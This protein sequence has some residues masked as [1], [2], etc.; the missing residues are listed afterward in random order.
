MFLQLSSVTNDTEV[1]RWNLPPVRWDQTARYGYVPNDR[2]KNVFMAV[3][4]DLGNAYSPFTS[5]HPTNK[6][7][8]GKRLALSSLSVAYGRY[9]Y[10]TGPLVSEIRQIKQHSL[11]ALRV[12]F[13]SV[14]GIIEVRS[15]HGFEVLG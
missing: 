2:Q 1:P 9:G 15:R 6:K 11:N 4:M 12:T 13:T 10:Y 14:H 8:V 3:A 5:I 7:D